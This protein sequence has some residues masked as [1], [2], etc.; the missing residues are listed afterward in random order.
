MRAL[1]TST[2][3]RWTDHDQMHGCCLGVDLVAHHCT[4]V[5]GI[6]ID[7]GGFHT[8]NDDTRHHFIVRMSR[9][10]GETLG[11]GMRPEDRHMRP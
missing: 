9:Q 4:H 6:E 8:D 1:T 5:P 2:A 11:A 10:I 7:Q 3:A